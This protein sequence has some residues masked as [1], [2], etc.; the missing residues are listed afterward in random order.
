VDLPVPAARVAECARHV[1]RALNFGIRPEHISVGANGEPGAATV[2]A[3]V[4]LLEPLGSDTLGLVRLGT[5]TDAGEM[6]GRFPPEAGL[7]VGQA[8]EVSLALNRLHLF[9]PETGAAIRGADW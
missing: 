4:M 9:D 3:Q 7:K 2:P 8:L 6:T 5:G 1:G